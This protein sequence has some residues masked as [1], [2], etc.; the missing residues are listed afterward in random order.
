MKLAIS[1]L[2]AIAS[3][4][5]TVS[6]Q[7]FV[8]P[9]QG[10]EAI[11]IEQVRSQCCGIPLPCAQRCSLSN[12]MDQADGRTLVTVNKGTTAELVRK[13]QVHRASPTDDDRAAALYRANM[14]MAKSKSSR[15]LRASLAKERRT[16][17]LRGSA[18]RAIALWSLPYDV[19]S[20]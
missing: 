18:R 10:E 8:P 9:T 11:C 2:L 20:R 13:C 1:A 4:A 16:L 17:G 7:A 19:G 5:T 6:A 14:S 12:W 3:V 15:R